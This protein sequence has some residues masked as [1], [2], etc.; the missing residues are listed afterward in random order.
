MRLSASTAATL[1]HLAAG[2][3]KIAQA[4]VQGSMDMVLTA[5]V[6]A[7]N[8]ITV[9]GQMVDGVGNPVAGVKNI[10]V[11]SMPVSGTGLLTDGGAGTAKAG[12]GS[13]AM[14]FQTDS[15]GKFQVAVANAV[16]EQNLV[17]V[18]TDNGDVA[19]IVLTFA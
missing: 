4:L 12:S 15:L 7:G 5:G 3:D 2:G 8:S 19:Q 6:E 18:S 1:K 17:Q 16:A 13:T 9:T 14:W 10:R 11:V